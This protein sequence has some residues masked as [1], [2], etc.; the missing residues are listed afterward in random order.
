MQISQISGEVLQQ[1]VLGSF[2]VVFF[3][4]KIQLSVFSLNNLSDSQKKC[5]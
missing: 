3:Y 4:R 5:Q 1:V 2:S